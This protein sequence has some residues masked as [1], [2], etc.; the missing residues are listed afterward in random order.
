MY[1]GKGFGSCRARSDAINA[2]VD[3]AGER[4]RWRCMDQALSDGRAQRLGELHDPVG[5]GARRLTLA[6]LGFEP[7]LVDG[8]T[9][10]KCRALAG[11]KAKDVLNH[12]LSLGHKTEAQELREGAVAEP[13]LES[14]SA[15]DGFGFQAKSTRSSSRPQARERAPAASRAKHRESGDARTADQAPR[16]PGVSIS[17]L[18]SVA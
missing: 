14:W 16:Q 15:S 13:S 17:K 18:G 8:A 5:V 3:A 6:L 7:A 1:V 11:A 2:R 12:R 9:S 4:G 10:A